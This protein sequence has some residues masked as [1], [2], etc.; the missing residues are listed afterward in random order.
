MGVIARQTETTER[1]NSNCGHSQENTHLDGSK[2][3]EPSSQTGAPIMTLSIT[4]SQATSDFLSNLNLFRFTDGA[5]EG[6]QPSFI[7]VLYKSSMYNTN[8]GK[9][10]IFMC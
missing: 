4:Y 1:V 2:R 7:H 8:N 10:C 6:S 9:D 5:A 3:P